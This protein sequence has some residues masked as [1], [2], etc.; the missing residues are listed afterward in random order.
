ME[1]NL[2]VRQSWLADHR[3][4]AQGYISKWQRYWWCVGDIVELSCNEIVK[5]LKIQ[6][7]SL[8]TYY[9]IKFLIR[10]LV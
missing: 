2:G 7:P 4:C 9:K 8:H 1:K 3:E 10:E 5:A 6:R